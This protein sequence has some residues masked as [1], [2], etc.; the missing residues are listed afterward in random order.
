MDPRNLINIYKPY[1]CL[2]SLFTH[3]FMYRGVSFSNFV[4]DVG[5]GVLKI[6]Y[7]FFVS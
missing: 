6:I 2:L 4:L 1:P 3:P 7:G 5:V